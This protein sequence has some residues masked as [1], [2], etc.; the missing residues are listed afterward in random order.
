MNKNQVMR[1]LPKIGALLE[2]PDIKKLFEKF[3]RNLITRT[4]RESLETVRL[5]QIK[6]VES[7]TVRLKK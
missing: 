4:L 2:D 6:A 3:N 7:E 5:E 1:K